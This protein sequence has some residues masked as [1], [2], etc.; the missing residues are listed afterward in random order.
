M[1]FKKVVNLLVA[2]G[3]TMGSAIAA[4][5][6]HQQHHHAS[7]PARLTLKEGL[8]WPTDAPLRSGMERVR[9]QMKESLPAIHTGKLSPSQYGT[10]AQQIHG[11]INT[12]IASC[13]LDPQA[14]G[15]LHI[16]IGDMLAS[17]E[18]MGG[19]S[20]AGRH[21]GAAGIIKAL[22]DYAAYFDHPGWVAIQP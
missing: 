16:L 5:H 14:D 4:E 18:L 10:L 8:K 13:K 15:Q 12:I 22:D 3:L 6:S 11:E 21:K 1:I 2:A 7:A 17:V 9:N 19:K 20:K